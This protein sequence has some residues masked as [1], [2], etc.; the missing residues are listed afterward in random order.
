M[1]TITTSPATPTFTPNGGIPTATPRPG[2]SAL[3]SVVATAMEAGLGVV[4]LVM[5][6][7]A[8]GT[9]AGLTNMHYGW[10]FGCL[11]ERLIQRIETEINK[12]A[13]SYRH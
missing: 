1:P 10:E 7:S 9:I 2:A 13:G 5:D 8:F 3:S 6:N 11:F 4:W 12:Q